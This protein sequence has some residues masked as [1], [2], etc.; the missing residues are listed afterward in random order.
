MGTA[1]LTRSQSRK[2]SPNR[3]SEPSEKVLS[4]PF[5]VLSGN[6]LDSSFRRRTHTE[7]SNLNSAEK[8]NA[9]PSSSRVG[10]G[11]GSGRKGLA[12][13]SPQ[14]V[15]KKNRLDNGGGSGRKGQ[16]ESSPQMVLK[17]RKQSEQLPKGSS[18]CTAPV[19]LESEL[20]SIRCDVQVAEIPVGSHLLSQSKLVSDNGLS[21]A[22]RTC[23]L[24]EDQTHLRSRCL[25]AGNSAKEPVTDYMRQTTA[26]GQ[27]GDQSKDVASRQINND[28]GSGAVLPSSSALVLLQKD[29][30]RLFARYKKLKAQRLDEVDA[31]YNEQNSR[32]SDFVQATEALL[33]FYKG[34]NVSLKQQIEVASSSELFERFKHLEKANVDC[35]NELLQEQAKG[36]ELRQENKRLKTSLLEHIADKQKQATAEPVPIQGSQSGNSTDVTTEAGNDSMSNGSAKLVCRLLEC[37]LG[38]QLSCPD[39]SH[40]HFHH[41]PT[42]F[43][44]NIKEAHDKEIAEL[45][46]GDFVDDV[47][48]KL[49]I[50]R[51]RAKSSKLSKKD[52]IEFHERIPCFSIPVH[53]WNLL[54]CPK[55]IVP[56]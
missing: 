1:R 30:E 50:C 8:E 56:R 6:I 32:I 41:R 52:G 29:Y 34:E 36:L 17:K 24:F 18:R 13:S 20:F 19:T 3:S 51:G 27:M 14:K 33:E 4:S 43:S 16:A 15:M 11:G 42:G 22:E 55:A 48:S 26:T 21:L 9:P 35:R 25:N 38:L 53:L 37:V 2:A 10:N 45:V 28:A 5:G 44:F 23:D 40:L 46:E 12:E 31:L 7:A 47:L 49:E 54:G 39:Q